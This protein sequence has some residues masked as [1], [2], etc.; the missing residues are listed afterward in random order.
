MAFTLK[1]KLALALAGFGILLVGVMYLMLS[2]SLEQGVLAQMDHTEREMIQSMRQALEARYGAPGQGQHLHDDPK[3]WGEAIRLVFPQPPRRPDQPGPAMPP[4]PLFPLVLLNADKIITAGPH[5][6]LHQMELTPLRN[7][8]Q[9]IFGYLGRLPGK[10]PPDGMTQQY[11]ARQRNIMLAALIIMAIGSVAFAWPLAGLLLRPI[12]RISKVVEQ[13]TALDYSPRLPVKST[14]ELGRLASQLNRLAIAL[15]EHSTSQ[16]QW[17]TDLAHELRTPLAVLQG[18]LEALRDRIRSY[19]DD[20]NRELSAQVRHLAHLADDLQA[21]LMSDRASLRYKMA[22]VNL[23]ELIQDELDNHAARLHR[24]QLQLRAD[25]PDHAMIEGDGSKLA[26]LVTNLIENSIRYTDAGGQLDIRL[27]ATSD[28][29]QLTWQDSAPGVP[30]EALPHL[31]ERFFRVE[32]SRDRA[33]GGSGLGLAI[34]AN[35][36]HGHDGRIRAEHSPL[37][38]LRLIIDLPDER[39]LTWQKS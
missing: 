1:A 30:E 4:R 39:T 15:D 17:L 11:L 2:V 16:R 14:D 12:H 7:R 34:V 32:A 19:N 21:L 27:R 33:K 26:R 9:Q 36:V 13:L 18:E 5:L 6:A 35:I 31:F 20:T 24:S 38:G 25:L 28:G 8:Q 23:G 29:F 37:G 10:P 22:P 3:A